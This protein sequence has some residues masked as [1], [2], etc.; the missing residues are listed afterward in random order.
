LVQ[1]QL[2]NPS[3]SIRAFSKH[4][5]IN[6]SALSEI[7]N[8]KRKVGEKLGRR[9]ADSLLLD[10]HAQSHLFKK[11]DSK[12]NSKE[13]QSELLK[14]DHFKFVADWY[15]FAILSLAE[16]EAFRSEPAWISERLN[17]TKTQAKNA[18]DRMVRLGL[19]HTK[20]GKWV[21]TG[22]GYDSPDGVSYLAVRK[23]HH[24]YLELARR[25][26]DS[27]ALDKR[28]FSAVTMAIDP[29]KLPEAKRRIRAFRDE[30]CGFLESGQ[31]KRVYQFCL[32]LFALSHFNQEENL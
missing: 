18:L 5:G 8:G 1:R 11:C 25:A 10:E 27:Q 23:T 12:K 9:L 4:L 28:D 32:Q 21:A 13:R 14:A 31:K 3:Y 26:L 16:T 29:K 30:L 20:E 17:I 22:M 7:F 19:L 6:H 24:Q 2:R 15:H